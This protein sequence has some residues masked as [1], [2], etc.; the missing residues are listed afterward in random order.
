MIPSIRRDSF[1]EVTHD[2]WRSIMHR[3]IMTHRNLKR[4]VLFSI[5]SFHSGGHTFGFHLI[6][7]DLEVIF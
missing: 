7:Q 2:Q 6:V 4:K 1:L 5:E 3:S